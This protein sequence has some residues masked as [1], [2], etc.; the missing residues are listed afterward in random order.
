MSAARKEASPGLLTRVDSPTT[1]GRRLRRRWFALAHLDSAPIKYPRP[2]QS[3][4]ESPPTGYLLFLACLLCISTGCGGCSRNQPAAPAPVKPQAVAPTE[5]KL[6]PELVAEHN[7]GV[8]HMGKFE[9]A[10]A[11][12]IFA[13]LAKRH[14][15]WTDVKVDLAIATF[16]QQKPDES[17]AS[18]YI[19]DSLAILD[20]VLKTEPN[21]LR[22]RYCKGVLLYYLG[23][24][25][26]AKTHFE[27]VAAKDPA[28]AFATYFVGRCQFNAGKFDEALAHYQQA[29]DR[30]PY[31]ASAYYA[32]FQ[33]LQRLRR[34]DE[35]KV[36]MTDFQRLEGNPM[37]RKEAMKYTR[38]GAKAEV[39]TFTLPDT[40]AETAVV[41]F[42]ETSQQ[43]APPEGVAWSKNDDPQAPKPSLTC[44]DINGDGRLDLFAS[45][46]VAG[47]PGPPAGNLRN[48]IDSA[49]LLGSKK[50]GPKNA[51]LLQTT[52]GQFELSLEHPLASVTS[53]NAVVWGDYD[54]DGLVDAYFC[55]QEENQLWRQTAPNTWDDVTAATKTGGSS[56]GTQDGMM[57]DIDHDGDL[58]LCTIDSFGTCHVRA[59]NRDGTFRSIDEELFGRKPDDPV[60][61]YPGVLRLLLTDFDNDRDVDIGVLRESGDVEWNI[62]DRLWSVKPSYSLFSASTPRNGVPSGVV[63]LDD[64]SDGRPAF[65]LIDGNWLRRNWRD[66]SRRF[67]DVFPSDYFWQSDETRIQNPHPRQRLAAADFDGDAKWDI[68]MGSADEVVILRADNGHWLLQQPAPNMFAWTIVPIDNLRPSL[69]WIS[70]E[71]EELQLNARTTKGVPFIGLTFSGKEEKQDEMRSNRSG[72]GVKVNAR[73]GSKWFSAETFRNDSGPGQSLMPLSFGT[74][75]A[76]K[77]DFVMLHWSDGVFQ[78]ETNLEAG[79]LHK[80][81]ETQRQTSSC[82]LLFVWDGEKF[83]FVT[84][85]L[86]VGGIGF[87]IGH[88]EYPPPD[89]TEN[90]LLPEAV[91]TPRDGRYMLKLHEPMEEA[92]YL[93]HAQL[94]VYDLPPGWNLV[95]DERFGASDPQPTGE[96]IY[97]RHELIP[98]RVRNDRG[99]DVTSEV[100]EVDNQAAPPGPRDARFV[101]RT[102]RSTLELEFATPL[103]AH[104]GAPVLIADGW[105]EY[106]YSQTMFAAWQAGAKY[107]APTLEARDANGAWQV[108]HQDFGYPAGMPRRMALPL[109]NLP[110]GTMAL[111]LSTTYEVYWDRLAVAFSE[112]CPKA[113]RVVIPA[114]NAKLARAGFP[115]RTNGPQRRPYYDYQQRAPFDDMRHQA[116]WY[117]E[118]GDVDELVSLADD[119]L[120]IFGPGE[121][122]HLEFAAPEPPPQRWQRR[123]VLETVGWCKDMDLMTADGDTVD[124]LPRRASVAPMD[125]ARL[126]ERTRTRYESGR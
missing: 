5:F 78:T 63:A 110:T 102:E 91:A 96:A 89:P 75:G 25:D 108:V 109:N 119:A 44:C 106:P 20:D 76:D 88:G 112:P 11:Q 47:N 84:D 93:D 62:S 77:V 72:I 125:A 33:T 71:G 86:G 57:I 99:E 126:H 10:P 6:T 22:A 2:L 24:T 117:T 3:A 50:L 26:E 123:L 65:F 29:I 81:E 49:R 95:L 124:P 61:G 40:K 14:P 74:A 90:L 87:N 98:S 85:L 82:P 17:F 46:L 56:N 8:G 16:N 54:N 53:V 55:R 7:V 60:T 121:E 80:I 21:H 27:F 15:G 42:S 101:G 94:A 79:K 12:A 107:E 41:E 1:C 51:V 31:F 4:T 9:F 48:L 43:F 103:D 52:D 36:L 35:A 58:D 19:V 114:E 105:V 37:A 66:D 34:P 13:D 104:V 83:A 115:R 118:F 111:R 69:V 39:L 38:M 73:I 70:K 92:T 18:Q 59:N 97:Y 32:A 28:D 30:D 23:K 45:A 67:S 120:A 116:G 100:A 113:R 64:D 122:V 68:A